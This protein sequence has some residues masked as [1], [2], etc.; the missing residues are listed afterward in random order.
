MSPTPLIS[1]LTENK[2]NGEKFQEWKRNLLIVLSYDKYKFILNE[3][4][5]PEAQP[6]VRN[7]WRDSDSIT[8]CYMLASMSNVLQ[9]QHENF[10]TAKEIITNLEDLLGGQV[11]LARQLHWPIGLP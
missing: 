10:H 11:A 1:I 7:R 3:T 9:K 4:C 2:L 6:K 8:R 5:P